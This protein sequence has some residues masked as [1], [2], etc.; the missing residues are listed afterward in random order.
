VQDPTRGV[1]TL[2]EQQMEG[3]AAA[4]PLLRFRC[5][6]CGYGASSRRAPARCPMCG[7]HQWVEEG[8]QPFADFSRDL[9]ASAARA[10][11]RAGLDADSPLVREAAELSVFPGVPLS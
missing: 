10:A 5:G 11:R 9:A 6:E 7:L 1:D 8:W 3:R 4:L 2:Y